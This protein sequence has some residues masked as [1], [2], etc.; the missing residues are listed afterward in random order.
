[1]ADEF[2]NSFGTMLKNDI[3][4]LELLPVLA[5]MFLGAP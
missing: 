5:G 4:F 1:M 2:Q 3:Q